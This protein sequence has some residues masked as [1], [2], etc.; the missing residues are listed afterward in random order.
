MADADFRSPSARVS[1]ED[2]LLADS[3]D[4][5]DITALRHAVT[6]H[7]TAAGLTHQRRDDFVLAV[8]EIVTNA[9]R[10]GGGH[11]WLRLWREADRVVCE[12]SDSGAGFGTE[13]LSNRD[14]PAANTAGGWG[15]WLA[16]QLSDD[17]T[18]CSGP[19]GTT[20]RISAGLVGQPETVVE[21]VE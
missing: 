3:F 4:E 10:H 13:W 21:A 6:A 9:V 20:V 15:L 18:V 16:E 19:E 5:G 1:A 11:G 8:N 7:A 14:R 12:V 2:T 17:M